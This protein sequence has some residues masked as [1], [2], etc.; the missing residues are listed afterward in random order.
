MKSMICSVFALCAGCSVVGEPIAEEVA[1]V[2]TKYC[3]REPYNA[4]Q[5]YRQTINAELAA[6]G[7]SIQVD[8]SG[9]PGEI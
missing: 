5:L 8:C 6:A 9:D 2:V 4:R 3:E 7:H 1:S